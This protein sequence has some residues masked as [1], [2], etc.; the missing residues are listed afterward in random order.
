MPL[1]KLSIAP[2]VQ[3]DLTEYAS[4]RAWHDSDKIRFRNGRVEPIGGFLTLDLGAAIIGVARDGHVW[5]E[6]DGTK[7][8]GFGTN[9]RLYLRRGG[10]IYNITPV[11]SSG[12]FGADPITT[13]NTSAVVTIVHA[14]H[15]AIK[16][17]AVTFAGATAVGGI[18][19]SGEYFVTAIIDPNSYT[20]THSS[21]ATSGATGGGA[22][23]TFSY[24]INPGPASATPGYGWGAG[25]W[26]GGTWGTARTSSNITLSLRTW[27]LDNWGEDLI[28]SPRSGTIYTW[29]ASGGASAVATVIAA[30]PDQIT[31]VVISPEDR[32]IIALG[33]D[34]DPLAVQ[35]CDQDDYT[36]WTAGVGSTSDIRRLLHGSMIKTG[37][38][39]KGEILLWT[40][41]ALYSLRYTGAG[42]YVFDLDRVGEKCPSISVN[43]V[44][45]R[46]GVVYW[47]GN[48]SFYMY[49]GRV[50]NLDCSVLRTVFNDLDATQTDKCFAVLNTD[51]KEIW[52]FWPS[53]SNGGEI[54]KYCKVNYKEG[55]W[56]I[57]TFDRT[58][59]VDKGPWAYPLAMSASNVIY[60]QENGTNADGGLLGD[61]IVSGEF[62]LGDGEEIM[63]SR[64]FIPDFKLEGSNTVDVT[65]KTRN[66]T[67]ADEPQVTSGPHTV[68]TATKKV[69]ARFR[70]RHGS[71]RI[72]SSSAEA[73]YRIG[74]QR[75]DI[76]P[77]GGQ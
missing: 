23:V 9:R 25:T 22:S 29:D 50:I 70:G 73:K 57:G 2:G 30:A 48:G 76:Q 47:M 72:E 77:D 28:A 31:K 24:E 56:D 55:V 42:D 58:W 44:V 62:D 40:D 1:T 61:Y 34:G 11:R 37:Q 16:D 3:A 43:S 68:S 26:G 71:V 35:W 39:T 4:E 14:S 8:I 53:L 6:N 41:T 65:I 32:H 64:R 19:I 7:V 21:A 74:D 49:N 33:A 59:W 46:D 20:I 5:A 38:R 67:N 52:F 54:D 63:F 66:Y 27:S 36:N 18:T 12:T 15:G 17:A 13:T 69:N 75:F 51:W 60:E 10:T 45:D